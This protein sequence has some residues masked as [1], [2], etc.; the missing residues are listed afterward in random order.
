M[1]TSGRDEELE[2]MFPGLRATPYRICRGGSRFYN[3]I[4]WAAG[5]DRR[6]WEPDEDGIEYWPP[7]VAREYTVEAYIAAFESIGY[8]KCDDNSLESGFEKVAIYAREGEPTHASWQL[9]D[10]RWTSKIGRLPEIDHT[11]EAL[12]GDEYGFPVQILRR[13]RKSPDA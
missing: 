10:G 6:W 11:F 8:S 12:D 7:G 5:D 2:D 9:D 13:A 1:D 3:C 4:A